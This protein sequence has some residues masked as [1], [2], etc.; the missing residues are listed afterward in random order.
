MHEAVRTAP[1]ELA[2][3]ENFWIKLGP[4]TLLPGFSEALVGAVADETRDFDLAVPEDFPLEPLKGK[5]LHNTVKV[6]E[7]KA[8][9]LPELDD[10]YAEKVIPGKPLAE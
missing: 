1:Q 9:A 3:K 4:E 7:L 10:A 6:P 2:G 8:Q 5:T